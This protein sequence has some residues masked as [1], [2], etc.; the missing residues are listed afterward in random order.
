MVR[1]S[2]RILLL[3]LTWFSMFAS[4][5]ANVIISF[6]PDGSLGTFQVTVGDMIGVPIYLTGDSRLSTQGLY[7]AGATVNYGYESGVGDISTGNASIV[8]AEL[9]AHWTG[10]VFVE[11]DN[12]PGQQYAVLEGVVDGPEISPVMPAASTSYILLGTVLFQSGLEGNITQL[13]LSNIRN[14]DFVNLLYNTE[15]GDPLDGQITYV[16]GNVLTIT[17][18]PEPTSLLAGVVAC[19]FGLRAWRR[20]T[21]RAV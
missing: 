8:Q 4:A 3:S 1:I 2:I 14:L 16:G 15:L 6:T 18:T 13:S 17:A 20:R 9:A 11:I 7:S 5:E 12:D 10:P 19:G 21:K